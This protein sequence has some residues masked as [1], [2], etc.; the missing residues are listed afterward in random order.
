MTKDGSARVR[1]YAIDT[2]TEC[3]GLVKSPPRT[4]VNVFPEYIFPI[5]G[6]MVTSDS[7]IG[8]RIALARNIANLAETSLRFLDQTRHI[9][10]SEF[11]PK[12]YERELATLHDIVQQIISCLFTDPQAIVKQTLV[13]FGIAK[14]CIFLG[15]NKAYDIVLSHMFTFLNDKDD[16]Y[17]RGSFFDCIVGVAAFVGWT[18]SSVL[19]PLLQ[20]GLTDSEEF[21]IAKAIRATTALVEL[22]LIDKPN[23]IQFIRDCSCFL[24]HPNIWIRHEIAGLIS[25]SARNLSALDV[26]SKLMPVISGYFK[27]PLILV[28]R[29]EILMDYLS[30]AHAVPRIIYDSV[31]KF[32]EI[33]PFFR[34]LEE[35]QQ[36]RQLSDDLQYPE[37]G[38][39]YKNVSVRHTVIKIFFF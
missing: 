35:R 14:I 31:V 25:T 37:M 20:Q 33:V 36:S 29:P 30:T 12:R 7:S 34:I 1:I 13:E 19:I 8:V 38:N 16:K 2:V 26:Q 3:L 15:R 27:S 39:V 28:D 4:D 6:Q 18:C 32:S 5:I 24:N 11:P 17:L 9:C 21:V 22:G 10:P 23:L